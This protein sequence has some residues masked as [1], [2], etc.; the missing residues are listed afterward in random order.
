MLAGAHRGPLPWGGGMSKVETG[1]DRPAGEKSPQTLPRATG[2]GFG[3]LFEMLAYY[4]LML[5]GSI[6]AA[7]VV[8]RAMAEL[9]IPLSS[10]GKTVAFILATLAAM[11]AVGCYFDSSQGQASQ[12]KFR[13]AA[14]HWAYPIT[15]IAG[16]ALGWQWREHG[17]PN[18]DRRQAEH[19]AA[20]TCGQIAFCLTQ[21]QKIA[22]GLDI[23]RYVKPEP[24]ASP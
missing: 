7:L 19:I 2:G 11:I 4:V 18:H 3:P 10:G 6:I 16:L 21:A 8:L 23:A 1:L 13:Q 20:S 24:P 14:T 17:D 5:A 15:L 12:A 9:S 22:G